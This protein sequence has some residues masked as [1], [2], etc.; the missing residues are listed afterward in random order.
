MRVEPPVKDV[1]LLLWSVQEVTD[2]RDLLGGG[3]IDHRSLH[4]LKNRLRR[5]WVVRHE[6][7]PSLL[8]RGLN[9]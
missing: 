7:L 8:H 3:D 4:L 5:V 1:D 9:L 6:G 2:S